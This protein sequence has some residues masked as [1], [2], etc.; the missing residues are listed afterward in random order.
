[1]KKIVIYPAEVLRQT[2]PRIEK[3]DGSLK[4][5][6]SELKKVLS[7]SANG[8]G[9]AATQIGL[10]RRFFGLKDVKTKEVEVFIN[11]EIEVVFGEK[12]YPK[13]KVEG[14]KDEDFLEG[15]LSFPD[16]YGTVKRFL[17]ITASWE[18]LIGEKLV[19]RKKDMSGFEAIVFQ[20]E[21]DHLNG[22][23]FVDRILEEGGK[24]YKEVNKEMV[25]W[26]VRKVV[27]GE[28]G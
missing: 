1:M 28:I 9:L 4:G 3:V 20:H 27:E 14:G 19:K 23:L 11:P 2:T 10:D 18:E 16:Y 6:V 17:K 8:A 15:C 13:I 12:V 26:E 7:A 5:D 22:V 25:V 21:L 24:F